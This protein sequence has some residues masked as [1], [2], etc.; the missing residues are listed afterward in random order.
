MYNKEQA[1]LVK[2]SFWRA[3]GRKMSEQ[4]SADD[5]KIK[6][7]NYET[8]VRYLAFKMDADRH[9]AII[10]IEISHPDPGIHELMYDQ[11]LEV[12]HLLE[13]FLQE[14]WVWIYRQKNQSGKE[15]SMIYAI[16]EGVNVFK[17][18]DQPL[19]YRFLRQRLIDLD[20]FWCNTN[21]A[22]ELF[23]D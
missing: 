6:W 20:R 22:F 10:K 21:P 13:E 11:F 2:E 17:P 14:E 18:A 4:L 23:K 5:E 3:F 16:T 19:I 7:I 8:G 12:K 15:V 9:S 1:S